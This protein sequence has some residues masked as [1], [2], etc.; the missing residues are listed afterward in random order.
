M[1][2][3]RR[4]KLEQATF[5]RSFSEDF[6]LHNQR[7]LEAWPVLIEYQNIPKVMAKQEWIRVA[8]ALT[9][10]YGSA[11][12][13][14]RIAKLVNT[15]VIDRKLL[16]TLYYD[17]VT[18]YLT[19]KLSFVIQWCG[20]GLDL[21][22]NYD[23]HE[24]ARI[25]TALLDLLKELNSIHERSGAN[26]SE[27][28]HKAIITRFEDRTRDFLSDPGRFSIGSDNYVENYVKITEV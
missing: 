22:A 6:E 20:T 18:G 24:L 21:A 1:I 17:E 28:G 8:D 12:F 16:Y 27:E 14:F 19:R 25:V 23:S 11:Q 3:T 26:L 4:G 15:G 10:C 13:L 2:L 5:L 9:G 7:F